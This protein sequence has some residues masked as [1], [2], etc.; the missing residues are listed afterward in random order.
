MK[1]SFLKFILTAALFAALLMTQGCSAANEPVASDPNVPDK[2]VAPLNTA[3]TTFSASAEAS[4]STVPDASYEVNTVSTEPLQEQ[5]TAKEYAS[6]Q[7]QDTLDTKAME[8]LNLLNSDKVHASYLEIESIDGENMFSTH[9]EYFVNGSDRIYINDDYKTLIINGTV[10][11]IDYESEIYYSYP[12][13]GV[14]GLDFGYELPLYRLISVSEE[15]GVLTEE[16]SVEGYG[17][18]STWKFGNDGTV[19]V[20]DRFDGGSFT[21]YTFDTID[22][23]TDSMDFSIPESFTEVDAEEYMNY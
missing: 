15:D 14:Y 6:E 1:Q 3:V 16:Y 10:T 5:T 7:V 9:R 23:A 8:Y 18:T 21:L 22:G 20:S 13:E 19:K 4:A 2:T 17:L 11:Y 12:D